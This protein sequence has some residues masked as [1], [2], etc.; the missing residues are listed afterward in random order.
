MKV[1]VDLEK[2]IA[3][4]DRIAELEKGFESE[5]EQEYFHNEVTGLH[6]RADLDRIA[7]LESQVENLQ[8]SLSNACGEIVRLKDDINLLAPAWTKEEDWSDE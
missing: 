7:E 1:E 5:G 8:A 3:M 2:F 4:S 6:N